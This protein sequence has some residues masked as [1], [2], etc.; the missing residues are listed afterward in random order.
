[1]LVAARELNCFGEIVKA[2]EPIPKPERWDPIALQS[3]INIG[4]IKEVPEEQVSG[5]KVKAESEPKP[6]EPQG[7][8]SKSEVKRL[9]ALGSTAKGF[10][11]HCG[12]IFKSQRA[13]SVHNKKSHVR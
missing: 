1:M 12:R 11:C 4:W 5:A 13:L 3:N 2:G 6:T 9:H 7:F 8:V 10:P